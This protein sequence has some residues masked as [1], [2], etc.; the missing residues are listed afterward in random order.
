MLVCCVITILF[1]YFILFTYLFK[2]NLI[3]F[4]YIYDTLINN[5]IFDSTFSP[6]YGEFLAS[7]AST[8]KF[9][10]KKSK[11]AHTKASSSPA[12][13]QDEAPEAL[14]SAKGRRGRYRR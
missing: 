10:T 14:T 12:S 13:L 2:I 5:C 4:T 11:S 6:T 3:E 1:A 8:I 9:S 7:A